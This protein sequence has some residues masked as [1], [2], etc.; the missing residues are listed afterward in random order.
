MPPEF[1]FLD[2]GR[3]IVS[4][5][6][7]RAIA[8]TT[9]VSG[10]DPALVA[11]VLLDP[12]LVD[13][14][15]RGRIDWREF[16]EAFCR[17]TGT[18]PEP[19]ALAEAASDMFALEIAMLPVIAR[20]TRCG[21]RLGILSNTCGPHWH[22]LTRVAGYGVLA[23]GFDTIVLS[24]EVGCRKPEPEIFAVAA[25]RAGMAPD[26]IF[27]TDDIEEHVLA[28]R[29]AGWD[30]EVFTSAVAL[31]EALTRRGLPCSL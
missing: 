8:Q 13:S 14:L 27:F 31:A 3:V 24:H 2:L 25:Q 26:R 7:D 16:H 1:V 22:H 12:V 4:F 9:T 21:C 28:A 30:A 6:R 10:A 19:A 5:D 17:R 23:T 29:Q 11:E 15:E 18:S 20:L